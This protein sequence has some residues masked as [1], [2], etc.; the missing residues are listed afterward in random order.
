HLSPHL[1]RK[2]GS[3]SSRRA[4]N[5]TLEVSSPSQN[6]ST[7][8][9]LPSYLREDRRF[10]PHYMHRTVNQPLRF[11]HSGPRSVLVVEGHQTVAPQ[12]GAIMNQSPAA[13]SAHRSRPA[14]VSGTQG[15]VNSIQRNSQMQSGVPP[16][17]IEATAQLSQLVDSWS[18]DKSEMADQFESESEFEFYAA[19]GHLSHELNAGNA[20]AT[21][22]QDESEVLGHGIDQESVI[23]SSTPNRTMSREFIQ[24]LIHTEI[25]RYQEKG[26]LNVNQFAPLP[27]LTTEAGVHAFIIREVAIIAPIV[28]NYWTKEEVERRNSQALQRIFSRI[29]A[30]IANDSN[31]GHSSPNMI[32]DFTL[33]DPF[34]D[35]NGHGASG[36][37]H[38]QG[39]SAAQQN[40]AHQNAAQQNAARQNAAQQNG[41]QHHHAQGHPGLHVN[42]PTLQQLTHH[43]PGPPPIPTARNYAAE[44]EPHTGST[45]SAPPGSARV[46]N[47][48]SHRASSSAAT[49]SQRSHGRQS[50]GPSTPSQSQSQP[51]DSGYVVQR[52]PGPFLYAAADM[53]ELRVREQQRR[54][55]REERIRARAQADE[56]RRADR[57]QKKL[58]KKASQRELAPAAS[59]TGSLRRAFFGGKKAGPAA[60]PAP[61]MEH[62]EEDKD[63]EDK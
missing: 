34:Y 57:A 43:T 52:T 4:A 59:F 3:L 9:S 26:P 30:A 15:E 53:E 20:V 25:Q 35:G 12:R 47:S 39:T 62:E 58:N 1:S 42:V 19:R 33:H 17:V 60:A 54:A 51:N 48:S 45:S 7:L 63:K 11:S 21:V 31:Q 38:P 44:A 6:T 14:A 23:A 29:T 2:A 36:A 49:R 50:N 55:A 24:T 28:S 22:Q 40:G 5:S 56:K 61:P 27:P 13:S 32:P 10:S 8:P 37:H 16:A 18:S 46:T 41:D